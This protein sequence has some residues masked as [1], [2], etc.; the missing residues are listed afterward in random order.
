M[1]ISNGNGTG[2]LLITYIFKSD[3][4]EEQVKE[5]LHLKNEIANLLSKKRVQVCNC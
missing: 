3:N 1:S 4:F 5:E 2:N